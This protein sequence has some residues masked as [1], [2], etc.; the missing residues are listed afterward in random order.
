MTPFY[1]EA[2]EH[3][4]QAVQRT[5]SR[6]AHLSG[7]NMNLQKSFLVFSPNTPHSM[8]KAISIDLGLKLSSC[9]GKYLGTWIDGKSSKKKVVD[10]VVAKVRNKLQSWKSRTIES[11]MARFFWGDQEDKRKIHL[12]N[13]RSLC[14]PKY[15]GGLGCCD[16]S[17]LNIALLAK[18]LW[19]LLS[20]KYSYA[21]YILAAKY[22]D[23]STPALQSVYSNSDVLNISVIPISATNQKDGLIWKHA[24]NGE[25]SVNAS[26][27]YLISNDSHNYNESDQNR[28]MWRKLWKFRLPNRIIMVMWKLLNNSLPTFSILRSHHLNVSEPCYLCGN[29][30]D[31]INHVFRHC[32]FA[33]AMWFG[34]HLSFRADLAA[35]GDTR[36][37]ERWKAINLLLNRF[38]KISVMDYLSAEG[39]SI[40][41]LYKKNRRQNVASSMRILLLVTRINGVAIVEATYG[42]P[43]AQSLQQACLIVLRWSLQLSKASANSTTCN[44]FLQNQRWASL[45]DY[46]YQVRKELQ[47]VGRDIKILRSQH[48]NSSIFDLNNC[49]TMLSIIFPNPPMYS[50]IGWTIL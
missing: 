28:K 13:W 39:L 35:F 48:C 20:Q 17:S 44:L 32:P 2:T 40:F 33:R 19:R 16:V 21:S 24:P 4:C 43:P 15:D 50:R 7:Q 29:Q 22:A 41:C 14:R 11:I 27:R 12:L 42:L 1:F 37:R 34:S 3:G 23:A 46:G 49:M 45:L 9:L 25:Y 6:Y 10:E 38:R 47:V 5:L 8:K 26:Y 31:N 30:D 36:I 18:H